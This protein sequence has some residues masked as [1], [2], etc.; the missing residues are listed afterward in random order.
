[1][2]PHTVTAGDWP[3]RVGKVH[4]RETVGKNGPLNL[5]KTQMCLSAF[6]CYN[7]RTQKRGIKEV[8]GGEI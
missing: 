6:L 8:V 2:K 4:R 3:P 7:K 1:M 5:L